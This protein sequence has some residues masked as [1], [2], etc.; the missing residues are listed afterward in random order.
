[1]RWPKRNWPYLCLLPLLALLLIWRWP[2]LRPAL[3]VGVDPTLAPFASRQPDGQMAGLDVELAQSLAKAL[4]RQL[5]LVEVP[6]REL[7]GALQQGKVQ[8]VI[9]ALAIRPD[10]ADLVDF[11]LPYYDATQVLVTSASGPPP[12]S[13]ADQLVSWQLAVLEGSLGQFEVEA[14][15][16]GDG[17]A[18]LQRLNTVPEL[19]ESL[20]TGQVQA[21]VCDRTAAERYAARDS[22]LR[23]SE[24][25]WWEEQYAVAVAKGSPELL[26]AVQA[27]LVEWL[28]SRQWEQSLARW[29]GP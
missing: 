19:F 29:I 22:R 3:L 10:R 11:S 18:G 15:K 4:R 14:I 2:S 26:A 12:P 23:L 27:A 25:G 6:F 13:S 28:Q 5:V 17:G 20:R 7:T 8:L 16:G 9:S 21:V 24:L 1:M